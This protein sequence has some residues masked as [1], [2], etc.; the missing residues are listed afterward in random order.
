MCTRLTPKTIIAVLSVSFFLFKVNV[1]I[2]VNTHGTVGDHTNPNNTDR[3]SLIGTLGCQSERANK[4]GFTPDR[5][6]GKKK[7]SSDI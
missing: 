6:R 4:V 7:K 5:V 2:F 1:N 3:S